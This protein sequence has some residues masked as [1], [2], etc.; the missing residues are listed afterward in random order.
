LNLVKSEKIHSFWS[1]ENSF[2]KKT[3]EGEMQNTDPI[4]ACGRN[5]RIPLGKGKAKYMSLGSRVS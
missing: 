2:L 4:W 5:L 1:G 3:L